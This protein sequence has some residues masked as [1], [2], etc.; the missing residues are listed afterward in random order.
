MPLC[1]GPGST[2]KRERK[3]ISSL[4]RRSNRWG[5]ALI[6]VVVAGVVFSV[7]GSALERASA[8]RRALEEARLA[9]LHSDAFV[10][11][12]AATLELPDGRK[13]GKKQEYGVDRDGS[14]FLIISSNGRPIFRIV[15]RGDR[16]IGTQF[17]VPTRYAEVPFN[18]DFAA[19]LRQMGGAQAQIAAPPALVARLGGSFSAFLDALRLGV[20]APLS[21]EGVETNGGAGLITVHLKAA[22]GTV[23]VG[24]DPSTHRFR[25]IHAALGSGSQQVRYSGSYRLVAGGQRPP[26]GALKIAG[27]EAVK[28]FAELAGARYPL[29]KPAPS[30]AIARL[31]GGTLELGKLRGSVVVLD[32]WATWCV[33]C[34]TAL[35]HTAELAAW[36]KKSNLPVKVFAVDT[37]ERT[38][39]LPKQR[40]LVR[41]FLASKHLDL[42]VLLDAGGAAFS[43]LHNPGLPSLV[44]IDRAGRLA[45]Y[46]SGLLPDM[47]ATVE[48]EVRQLARP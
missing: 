4:F 10:E 33:P 31:E 43:A 16:M 11:T 22:N 45:R 5:A 6:A 39:R 41:E 25:E 35:G 27:R 46:H 32:F 28:T 12:L 7:P 17:D 38:S 34:W 23:T 44:I 2:R 8:G 1:S 47:T 13:E 21:V 42:P 40:K 9:Y 48:K 19:A 18:G 15:A 37:L 3:V 14:S 26:G 29:E 30:L 20:L 24:L 36:A